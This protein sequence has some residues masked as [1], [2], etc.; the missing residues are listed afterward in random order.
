MDRISNGTL[1]A[2]LAVSA[3]LMAPAGMAQERRDMAKSAIERPLEGTISPLSFSNAPARGRADFS[4]G[5]IERPVETSIQGSGSLGS[6]GFARTPA[7]SYRSYADMSKDRIERPLESSFQSF[8]NTTFTTVRRQPRS[9]AT[10][11]DVQ[12]VRP[13]LVSWHASLAEACDASRQSGKPVLVFQM[14]GKLD[15]KF[16]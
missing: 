7:R 13:G 14:M 11:S 8:G 6:L 9:T 15:E 2:L 4:K 3:G 16:C 1:V 12:H 5:F 10:A